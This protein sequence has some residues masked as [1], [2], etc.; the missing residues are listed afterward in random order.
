M[1]NI[2]VKDIHEDDFMFHHTYQVTPR[3]CMLNSGRRNFVNQKKLLARQLHRVPAQ[4][5]QQGPQPTSASYTP[6]ECSVTRT[7]RMT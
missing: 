4:G 3:W 6:S 2:L 7:T 1:Q 5:G